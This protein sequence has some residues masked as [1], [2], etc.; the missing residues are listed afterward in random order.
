MGIAVLR[1]I[2]EWGRRIFY[3]YFGEGV[4][5]TSFPGNVITLDYRWLSWGVVSLPEGKS[6]GLG[7]AQLRAKYRL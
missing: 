7:L 2:A 1:T 4:L 3:G 5:F 6:R